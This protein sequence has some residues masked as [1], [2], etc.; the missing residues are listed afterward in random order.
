MKGKLILVVGV[1]GA[2][3]GTLIRCAREVFPE[4]EAPLSWTTRPMRPGEQEGETYHFATDEEFTH[5]VSEDKFL[6]WVTIDNGRRYGTLKEAIISALEAGRYVLREVE[7]MGAQRISQLLGPNT[8]S[9]F[10]TPGTWEE[11]QERMLARAPMDAPELA[12]RKERYEREV[13]FEAEADYTVVNLDG[14]LEQA[15]Q[16]FKQ[17]IE[18]IMSR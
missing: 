11:V 14:G 6:E 3:K 16:H 4:L 1:P 8:V 13:L 2:G 5:A 10:I 15:K 12:E 18:T 9:I 7:P 17:V